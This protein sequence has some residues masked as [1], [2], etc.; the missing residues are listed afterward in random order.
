MRIEKSTGPAAVR[1]PQ[2]PA[3]DGFSVPPMPSQYRPP[4]ALQMRTS[5]QRAGSKPLHIFGKEALNIFDP[6]KHSLSD[7]GLLK[8]WKQLRIDELKALVTLPPTNAFEEMIRWTEQ[9]KLWK[10]PIDNE[11]GQSLSLTHSF[12]HPDAVFDFRAG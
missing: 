12:A 4:P 7:S 11:A 9:G 6:E 3:E 10:Y 5:S 1:S 8:T 2:A